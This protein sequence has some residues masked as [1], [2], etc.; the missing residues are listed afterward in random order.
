MAPSRENSG[1]SWAR[2]STFTESICMTANA[3]EDLPHVPPVDPSRR[4]TVGEPLRRQRDAAGL[5]RRSA[6]MTPGRY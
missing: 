2:T 5:G 4:A 3:V 1:S 6:S